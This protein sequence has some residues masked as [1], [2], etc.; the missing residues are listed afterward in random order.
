MSDVEAPLL[1]TEDLVRCVHRDLPDSGY[2]SGTEVFSESDYDEHLEE[3][4]KD[5]PAGP[6][7]VFAY[8]SLIWKPAFAH[9][10]T[11]RAVAEGWRR[12]FC[13]RIKRFRGTQ[14]Q[15]GLMMALDEGGRCEGFLQRLHEGN[16]TS[17]LAKLWRREMTMKPPGNMPRW[18]SAE[19]AEGPVAAVAFTA[20]QERSNYAGDLSM[21]EIAEVLSVACGHWGSCA[22]YLR[23]TVL[24][25]LRAGIRDEYLWRL[26]EMVAERIMQ[27]RRL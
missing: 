27:R 18:I 14:E 8:G 19:G 15:P 2:D 7:H 24:A 12:S 3:F 4:L 9:A 1:L 26:Q 13:L 10:G 5:R 6:L 16:E 22:D 21:E 17:E 20:N 23:Q 25:L 11:T